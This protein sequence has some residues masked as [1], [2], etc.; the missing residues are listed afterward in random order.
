MVVI[1]PSAFKLL[2][3]VMFVL[4]VKGYPIISFIV[5]VILPVLPATDNT[6][7]FTVI[8]PLAILAKL[9]FIVLNAVRNGSP[10]PS[11]GL[12]PILTLEKAIEICPCMLYLAPKTRFG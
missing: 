6:G 4:L 9:L 1:L 7:A 10:V 2:I 12:D 5:K 8:L 3:L 11:S